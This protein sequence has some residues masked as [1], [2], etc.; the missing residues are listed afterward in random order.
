VAAQGFSRT[1]L[2]PRPWPSWQR[3][4]GASRAPTASLAA[5]LCCRELLL[6]EYGFGGSLDENTPAV[7]AKDIAAK[8][9]FGIR[10]PYTRWAAAGASPCPAQ[11]TLPGTRQD[12]QICQGPPGFPSPDAPSQRTRPRLSHGAAACAPA[13]ARR[14]KDPWRTFEPESVEVPTRTALR[15]MYNLTSDWLLHGGSN[16]YRVDGERSVR[17]MLPLARAGAAGPASGSVARAAA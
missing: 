1:R 17:A 7:K 11:R 4:L 6:A 13:R 9:W 15:K 12:D 5:P 14:A 3:A 16:K 2:R 8:S 10:G